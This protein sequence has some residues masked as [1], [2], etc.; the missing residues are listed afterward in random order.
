MSCFSNFVSEVYS[1]IVTSNIAI[2]LLAIFY[3]FIASMAVSIKIDI[4]VTI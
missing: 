3:W 4:L 1:Y 2:E